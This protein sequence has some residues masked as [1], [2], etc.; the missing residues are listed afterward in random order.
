MEYSKSSFYPNYSAPSFK[1]LLL[2]EINSYIGRH[3]FYN[4]TSRFPIDR[5]PLLVDLG[6][7]ANYTDGWVHVDFYRPRVCK[8]KYFIDS[9]WP[10]H[11]RMP[12]VETDLRY[13]LHCTDNVVDGVYTSHTLE[14]LW[15]NHAWQL[16]GEIFRILKPGCWLRIAVPDLRH[17]ID[18]YNGLE[19]NPAYKYRAEA[20]GDLTQNFG[21]HSVWDAEL[22]AGALATQGFVNIKEV[23]FGKTGTDARLIKEEQVRKPQTL[24]MEALKPKK[25]AT[26]SKT[27]VS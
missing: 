5:S 8:P 2:A 19:E 25:F 4:S 10:R 20:I 7:G 6:V 22:L 1:Q 24:V 21:H 13:P 16:L 3:F 12:E 27:C 26:N 9:W 11:R 14:H 17:A 15:P 18:F 23:E